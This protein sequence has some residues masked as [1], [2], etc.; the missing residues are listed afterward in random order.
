M[1]QAQVEVLF[2][3]R[4]AA[5]EHENL[6]SLDT[7]QEFDGGCRKRG[8]VERGVDTVLDARVKLHDGVVHCIRC[9]VRESKEVIIHGRGRV[10]EPLV[11]LE[12]NDPLP[13]VSR[14]QV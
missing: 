2:Q 12:A 6:A 7:A 9:S 1:R 10:V 8:A 5:L 14:W 11:E 4:Q 3:P 13:E